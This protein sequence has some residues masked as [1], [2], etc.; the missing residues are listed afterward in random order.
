MIEIN[1]NTQYIG[2]SHT[3][4]YVR[5]NNTPIADGVV[6]VKSSGGKLPVNTDCNII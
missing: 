3:L 5:A 1:K 4:D 6:D 2:H